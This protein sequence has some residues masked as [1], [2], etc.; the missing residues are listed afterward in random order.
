MALSFQSLALAVAV[1]IGVALA[2]VQHRRARAL[3]EGL[4]EAERA[5]FEAE[6]RD[7]AARDAMPAK[8]APYASAHDRA[9][10]GKAGAG[11]LIL[12]AL[13]VTIL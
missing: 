6:F 2:V 11:L 1:L 9:Q 7:R 3:A 4:T 12:V 5:R 8:F 13:L 10:G